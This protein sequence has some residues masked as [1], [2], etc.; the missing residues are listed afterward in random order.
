MSSSIADIVTSAKLP[1]AFWHS[2]PSKSPWCSYLLWHRSH[3]VVLLISFGQF[4]WAITT[5]SPLGH[6]HLCTSLIA[7]PAFNCREVLTAW[8]YFSYTHLSLLRFSKQIKKQDRLYS[9]YIISTF[10]PLNVIR[11]DALSGTIL[12]LLETASVRVFGRQSCSEHQDKLQVLSE[13]VLLQVMTGIKRRS[14]DVLPSAWQGWGSAAHRGWGSCRHCTHLCWLQRVEWGWRGGL[15]L[16]ASFSISAELWDR[17]SLLFPLCSSSLRSRGF[18]FLLVCSLHW[19]GTAFS[20]SN[21]AIYSTVQ[22]HRHVMLLNV[23]SGLNK[24]SCV[25]KGTEN[26]K[27]AVWLG[28]AL[29]LGNRALLLCPQEQMLLVQREFCSIQTSWTQGESVEAVDAPGPGTQRHNSCSCMF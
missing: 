11:G 22:Q 4:S 5:C 23:F 26:W 7:G 21:T 27:W 29:V 1:S 14:R 13:S 8:F 9:K 17:C 10:V 16:R 15:G 2:G 19:K 6:E 18:A 20:H 24:A 3:L 28:Q 12:L 25:I